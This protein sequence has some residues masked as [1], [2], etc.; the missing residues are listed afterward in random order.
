V[1]ARFGGPPLKRSK[2]VLLDLCTPQG[3]LERR[4]PSKGKLRP[5][6]GAY[7]AARKSTWGAR[8]PNWLSRKATKDSV[9][10][11]AAAPATGALLPA[12]PTLLPPPPPPSSDADGGDAGGDS[13]RRTKRDRSGQVRLSRRARR[14]RSLALAYDDA[15]TPEERAKTAHWVAP[16][17]SRLDPAGLASRGPRAAAAAAAAASAAAAAAGDAA[18]GGGGA[19][20]FKVDVSAAFGRGSD[21]AAASAR[22]RGMA[23]LSRVESK[24]ARGAAPSSSGRQSPRSSSSP[25]P[26]PGPGGDASDV[27]VVDVVDVADVAPDV[28]SPASGGAA[29]GPRRP[30]KPAK[31][32]RKP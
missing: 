17:A 20:A 19:R 16:D 7:R 27:E 26:P 21:A 15:V 5:F 30:A 11:A 28:G 24:V 23:A 14:K 10:A 3:T 2:H 29:G 8:W 13:S 9:P 25:S 12:P 1:A 4:I 6:P 32:A 31:A 22:A 18:R